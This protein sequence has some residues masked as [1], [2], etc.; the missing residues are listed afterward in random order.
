MLP[1][2]LST[3][4]S[5]IKESG[6]V[7]LERTDGNIEVHFRHFAIGFFK[8]HI[9]FSDGLSP[10]FRKSPNSAPTTSV[11]MNGKLLRRLTKRGF[12]KVPFEHPRHGWQANKKTHYSLEGIGE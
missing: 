7:V 11:S 5:K 12:G 4:A 10:P 1:S 2:H 6:A 8:L 3:V 9:F